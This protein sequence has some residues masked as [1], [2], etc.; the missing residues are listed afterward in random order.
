MIVKLL[1]RKFLY[2][3]Q[4]IYALAKYPFLKEKLL[5]CL[6]GAIPSISIETTNI[7]NANCTFCA[8][9]YQKRPTGIMEM[10][11]FK[12]IIDEYA[13]CGGGVV[14]FTP[15]VGDPLVD[16]YIVERIRYARSKPEISGVTMY[17]NMI[18][19]KRFGAK[20][21][22]ESGLTALTVSTSGFDESM[23]QRV[24]RSKMYKQVLSNIKVFAEAN[25][26][27]GDPV[28]FRITMRVDR[29]GS[30]VS[31]SKDFQE[32]AALVGIDHISIKFRYDSWAGK[33][34]QDQLS[35]NMKLRRISNLRNPRLSPCSAMYFGPMVYWDGKVGACGCRDVNA[36]EL[37]IGD[38]KASH[39]AEIWFGEEIR[40]LR[41]DFLTP[42]R[43]DICKN[44]SHYNNVAIFLRPDLNDFLRDLKP[45]RI[46]K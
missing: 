38:A 12:K 15:T 36:S 30:E 46:T 7:C 35:G 6:S 5:E 26:E 10:E 42:R 34:T 45:S 2:E 33:I 21:L 41:E 19:L 32:I 1:Y 8:Y 18:S 4:T 43:K 44:C 3:L 17:S 29:S 11:L 37:I 22:V 14:G 27:A 40:R 23:Y 28:D 24:Y 9:Q 13:E 39:L 25:R 16:P 31:A 20:A